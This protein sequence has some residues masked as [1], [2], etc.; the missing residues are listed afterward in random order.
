MFIRQVRV[1]IMTLYETLVCVHFVLNF[2]TTIYFLY[3]KMCRICRICFSFT[4][5]N[6]TEFYLKMLFCEIEIETG[7]FCFQHHYHTW[8]QMQY[9]HIKEKNIFY[10]VFRS[11][12]IF[13]LTKIKDFWFSYQHDYIFWEKTYRIPSIFYLKILAFT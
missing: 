4:V 1:S 8:N 11:K 10:D 12:L 2:S 6:K 7:N 5:Y 13:F 3:N 9:N